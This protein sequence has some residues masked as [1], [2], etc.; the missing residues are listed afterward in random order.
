ML[1]AVGWAYLGYAYLLRHDAVPSAIICPVRLL[2]G[3]RCP[4]CGMTRS[5]HA[6]LHWDWV[7]AFKHHP[8]APVLLPSAIG[9]SSA[10]LLH[11]LGGFGGGGQAVDADVRAG[12]ANNGE[13]SPRRT[14]SRVSAPS[15]A[16]VKRLLPNFT[17]H[18]E[19]T[20]VLAWNPCSA[21]SAVRH[22]SVAITPNCTGSIDK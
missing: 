17:D 10:L 11:F 13:A 18:V 4:L 2:T 15:D 3:R 20:E 8:V 21:R 16:F 5:W 12:G 9:A 19:G 22:G 6:A 7:A 14:P 1:A